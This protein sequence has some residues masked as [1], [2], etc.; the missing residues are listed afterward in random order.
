MPRNLRGFTLTELLIVIAIEAIVIASLLPA[1]QQAREAARRTQC[2]N[3]LNQSGQALHNDQDVA[4]C[5][6]RAS[7]RL[8]PEMQHAREAEC[9]PPAVHV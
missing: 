5:F 2:Q 6:L 4:W 1:V 3:H 7:G 9:H 8:L